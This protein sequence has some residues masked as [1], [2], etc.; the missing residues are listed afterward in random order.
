MGRKYPESVKASHINMAGPK[1]PTITSHPA[2][3][4]KIQTTPLTDAEKAGLERTTWFRTSGN[5]YFIEQATKPQTIGYSVTDS[6]VG[7]L[8]WIYEKMHDWSDNY[9]WTED[10][11]L[12]WICIYYFSTAGPAAS[13]RIYYESNQGKPS[14]FELVAEYVPDVKLGI[15]R[16]P[17]ELILLPKLWSQTLGPV[18]FESEYDSGGHFAAWERPEAIV[19]DLR[20]MFG[21][22]GG[23]YG[24]LN[25]KDGYEG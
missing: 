18:V 7:L 25:G 3:Y 22:A 8:A 13:Q 16:F 4:A 20:E 2:L 11:V 1:E 19:R 24:V 14:G 21:K 5:G 12:T 15:A 23:A 9:P 6:P 10:E 17:K